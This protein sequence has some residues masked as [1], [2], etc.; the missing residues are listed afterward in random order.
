[1]SYHFMMNFPT[2]SI[3]S[4][5]K[6]FLKGNKYDF[7]ISNN[8]LNVLDDLPLENSEGSKSKRERKK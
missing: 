6:G 7:V 8:E 1:M 3:K 4:K 5:E 2:I